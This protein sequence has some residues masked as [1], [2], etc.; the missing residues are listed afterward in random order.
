MPEGFTGN[1][2]PLGGRQA[3][4]LFEQ[5]RRQLL[6][7]RRQVQPFLALRD[8]AGGEFAVRVVAARAQVGIAEEGAIGPFEVEHLAQR[9]A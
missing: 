8:A 7:V 5:L 4:R 1:A 6:A 3:E 2:A 9:L